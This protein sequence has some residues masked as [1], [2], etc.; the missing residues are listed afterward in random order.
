MKILIG[1]RNPVKIEATRL[2]FEKVWP[3]VANE[4]EFNFQG[5]DVPSSVSS[6]PMSDEQCIIGARN[7]AQALVKIGE[8]DY[9]VGLEGGSQLVGDSYFESGWIVI[10]DK[11]MNEGVASTIKIALP[12]VMEKL[13]LEGLELGEVND[14]VFGITNSKQASGFFGSITNDKITRT[15]AYRDA[16]ICALARFVHADLYNQ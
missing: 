8:A 5:I 11:F 7:R 4:K 3:D 6:Q 2:A 12:K 15:D 14:K 10:L 13:I 16:V 1:S 9:Y